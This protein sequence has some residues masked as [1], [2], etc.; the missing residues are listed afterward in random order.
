MNETDQQDNVA[1]KV[2]KNLN[3]SV[4]DV[5]NAWTNPDEIAKWWLPEGF[6]DSAQSEVDLRVGGEFKLHMQPPEGDAFYAHGIFKEIVPN[7]KIK[8]T[9]LWSTS[10]EETELTI[11][12]NEVGDNTELVIL[13]EFFSDEEEK[14]KHTEGWIACLDRMESMF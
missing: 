1:L 9:W 10:D 14:N 3:A 5:W 6:S 13:H 8:S 12:F 7:S 4:A 11:E 2:S